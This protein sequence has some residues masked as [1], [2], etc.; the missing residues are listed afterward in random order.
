MFTPGTQADFINQEL[1]TMRQEPLSKMEAELVNKVPLFNK[2]N[3][4]LP[5]IIDKLNQFERKLLTEGIHK[6]TEDEIV[7]L[8]AITTNL[9][10]FVIENEKRESDLKKRIDELHRMMMQ[11]TILKDRM[12]LARATSR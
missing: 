5:R 8:F 10:K 2:Q 1:R 11:Q 9:I 12:S 7:Q 6:V 4:A 3:D